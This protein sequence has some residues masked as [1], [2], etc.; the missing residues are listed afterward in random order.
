MR[1]YYLSLRVSVKSAQPCLTLQ[2]NSHHMNYGLNR[3]EG[4]EKKIIPAFTV[5]MEIKAGFQ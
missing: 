1:L 2:M 4:N 3:A 5:K